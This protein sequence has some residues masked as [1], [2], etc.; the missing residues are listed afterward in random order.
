MLM[1]GRGWW[2]KGCYKAAKRGHRN[3]SLF[4]GFLEQFSEQPLIVHLSLD[5]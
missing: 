2:A 3:R 4:L 1:A 5:F